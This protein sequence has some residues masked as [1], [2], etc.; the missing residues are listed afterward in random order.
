MNEI[1]DVM[2]VEVT[3]EQS[4]RVVFDDGPVR[5][6]SFEGQLEGPVFEPL[7]DPQM[8]ARV[9]VDCETGSVPGPQALTWTRSSSTR[10]CRRSTPASCARPQADSAHAKRAI[11]ASFKPRRVVHVAGCSDPC[12]R[13]ILSRRDRPLPRA[14]DTPKVVTPRGPLGR[15]WRRPLDPSKYRTRGTRVLLGSVGGAQPSSPN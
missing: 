13:A 8:F 5:D 2:H 10:G 7:R 6:V 1:H 3:G 11:R 9:E 4:L 15:T 12:G 14:I